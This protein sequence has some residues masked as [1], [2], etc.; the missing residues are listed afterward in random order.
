MEPPISAQRFS[1]GNRHTPPHKTGTP[2]KRP[3][4]KRNGIQKLHDI[5]KIS[6]KDS[7]QNTNIQY[8]MVYLERATA[9]PLPCF[10]ILEH[11]EYPGRKA[12][13]TGT[14]G[15]TSDSDTCKVQA[16]NSRYTLEMMEEK[17][18]EL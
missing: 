7:S 11:D 14:T 17:R 8:I 13:R 10:L 9:H 15:S 2:T 4:T 1:N 5:C 16:R 12:A 3:V 6:T 18:A